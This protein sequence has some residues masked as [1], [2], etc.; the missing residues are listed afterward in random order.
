M[1]AKALP[2]VHPTTILVLFSVLVVSSFLAHS[3]LLEVMSLLGAC[4]FLLLN[5][6]NRTA[7]RMIAIALITSVAI[8]VINPLFNQAGDTI[9]FTYLGA[10]RYTL[11]AL[12]SGLQTGLIF[13]SVVLWFAGLACAI[14]EDDL[15]LLFGNAFPSLTLVLTLT[16]KLIPLFRTRA[17]DTISARRGLGLARGGS[18]FTTKLRNGGDVVTSLTTRALIG[19]VTTASSMESRGL[20]CGRRT[21]LRARDKKTI[22]RALIALVAVAFILL[23]CSVFFEGK[24]YASDAITVIG[25]SVFFLLCLLPSFLTIQ[26]WFACRFIPSKI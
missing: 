17:V 10:R 13:A 19:A 16:F 24:A 9:L 23:L 15:I 12:I 4:L 11:E 2:F 25:T 22:D 6:P 1:K 8:M 26:E 3:I 18:T 7:T 20:G 5:S 14:K 21:S